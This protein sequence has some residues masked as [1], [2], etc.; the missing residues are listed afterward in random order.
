MNTADEQEARSGIAAQREIWRAARARRKHER[1]EVRRFTKR[2]R[3]RRRGVLIA[4]SAFALFLA[5]MVAAVYSPLMNVTDVRVSGTQRLDAAAVTEALDPITN[6]PIA[7]VSDA[8]VE[9]ILRD[10]VL[11]QSY[12]VQ[13]IPP[14]TVIVHI[15]ERQPIGVVQQQGKVFVVDGAG[16]TLWEDDGAAA[17]LPTIATP[18][19]NTEEFAAIGRVLTAMPASFL[20]TIDTVRA[21]SVDSVQFTLRDGKRVIWGSSTDNG[22]K[23]H[24]LDALMQGTGD[25]VTEFDVSSPEQPVTRAG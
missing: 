18:V 24:V 10:F 1:A 9:A 14:G 8:E 22:M 17:K 3:D 11:V 25:D 19:T 13:R 4:G 20:A 15:V 23:L 6:Q 21:D 16:V 2:K 7:Q 12:T 5:L